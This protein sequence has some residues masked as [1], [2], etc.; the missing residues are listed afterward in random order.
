MGR[1]VCTG[2]LRVKCLLNDDVAAGNGEEDKDE[3]RTTAM[4]NITLSATWP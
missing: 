4:M 2:Y 3:R 1:G